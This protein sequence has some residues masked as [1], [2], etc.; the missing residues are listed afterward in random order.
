MR[1]KI[2]A[3]TQ[4]EKVGLQLVAY[5]VESIELCPAYTHPGGEVF[6]EHFSTAISLDTVWRKGYVKPEDNVIVLPPLPPLVAEIHLRIV[7]P[8]MHMFETTIHPAEEA[9]VVVVEVPHGA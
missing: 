2:E 6:A 3:S 4:V 7:V 1:I 9:T 8:G 5:R